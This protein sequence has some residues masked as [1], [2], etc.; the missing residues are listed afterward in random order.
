MYINTAAANITTMI[1]I[2][3]VKKEMGNKEDYLKW[4]NAII[5]NKYCPPETVKA[6]KEEM[7]KAE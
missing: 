3:S 6:I 2:A 7:E 5:T 4:C 1:N